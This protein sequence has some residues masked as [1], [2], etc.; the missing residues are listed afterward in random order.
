MGRDV[1]AASLQVVAELGD[2]VERV[3]DLQR[4]VVA[5][6]EHPVVDRIGV[7]RNAGDQ[8]HD[9]LL[10]LG[11]DRFELVGGEARLKTIQQRVIRAA[12]IPERVGDL[13]VELEVLLEG[14]RE[15]LEVGLPACLLPHG[16]RG[17]AGPSS[18]GY[19]LGRQLA[20]LLVVA[21]G[22]PDQARLIRVER[23]SRGLV[24]QLVEQPTDLVARET[25]VGK[26][27][28][29]GELVGPAAHAAWRHVRLLVP[30][31]HGGGPAQVGDLSQ[32]RFQPFERV[33]HTSL[34]PTGILPNGGKA[35]LAQLDRASAF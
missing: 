26:A 28:E 27:L 24:L 18:L 15:D 11:E 34:P 21:P 17:R 14:R 31:E 6:I 13:A 1:L 7:P 20:L 4:R 5:E 25:D 23:L 8:R 12:L 2:Q 32:D 9:R 3:L 19:E 30:F 22:D 33:T 16:P 29:S 10:E 35:P